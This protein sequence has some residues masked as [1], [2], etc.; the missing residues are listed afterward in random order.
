M[1]KLFPVLG[2]LLF[3]V[4]CNGEIQNIEFT[5]PEGGNKISLTGERQGSVGPIIVQLTMTEGERK[6][7]F[8]FEHQAGS[9]TTENVK[10]DWKNDAHA[11]LT[12]TLDDGA[13]WEVECFFTE[14]KL[15]AVKK[16]KVGGTIFD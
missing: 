8:S 7:G 3:L 6:A 4:G 14:D 12:F 13:M 15:Q 5:S 11:L 1:K 2:L 16:F 10:A 9:L